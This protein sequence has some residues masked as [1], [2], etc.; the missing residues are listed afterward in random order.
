[1][2]AAARPG[3][4]R[5]AAAEAGRPRR[6]LPPWRLLFAAPVLALVLLMALLGP[7]LPLPD[8]GAGDIGARLRPPGAVVQGVAF[9]L[10]TDALGRD[11]LSRLVAGARISVMVGLLAV[12]IALAL[13]VTLGLM[14]GY[15]GRWADNLIM[16]AADLQLGIPTLVLVIALVAAVGPGVANVVLVLGLSGWVIY[17][18][19][20]RGETLSVRERE[21]V[22]AARVIGAGDA[23]VMFRHIL[24]N[25]RD[26]IVVVATLQVPQMILA[27]ASLSFLG[28]GVQPPAATWGNMVADGRTY[29]SN[30]WWVTTVPGVTIALTALSL[31]LLG[32]WLRERLDPSRR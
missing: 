13:G 15:L 14:A 5:P 19:L 18:R 6:P 17:G 3:E 1:M 31:N 28:L 22:Q 4:P 12:G 10:G 30:A 29:L 20:V 16:R 25:V 24:P 32:D 23:R 9:P 21:Y 8:P 11:L 26:S 2:T 7:L 27:E